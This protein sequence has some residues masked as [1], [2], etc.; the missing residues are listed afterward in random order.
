MRKA[1]PTLAVLLLASA[2]GAAAARAQDPAPPMGPRPAKIDVLKPLFPF[3]RDGGMNVDAF[4]RDRAALSAAQSAP[5]NGLADYLACRSL[6]GEAPSCAALDGLGGSVAE[7][8]SA[9]RGLEREARLV[10]A[11]LGGGDAVSLCRRQFEG[12]GAPPEAVRLAC[13]AV[14]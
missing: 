8:S 2:S 12:D 14:V 11:A 3:C 6:A 5:L 7:A 1:L 10:A 13:A 9:C 4:V